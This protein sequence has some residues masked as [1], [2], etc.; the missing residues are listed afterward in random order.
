MSWYMGSQLTNT[1]CGPTFRALPMARRLASRLAWLTITPLGWPVLPEVYCRKAMSSGCRG[2]V[3][4][5]PP[6]PVS[7]ATL[8]MRVR[9]GTC[10]WSNRASSFACVTVISTLASALRRMPAWRRR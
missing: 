2:G 6:S 9:L 1:S 3:M 7:S 10:G 4:H 5:S 8:A